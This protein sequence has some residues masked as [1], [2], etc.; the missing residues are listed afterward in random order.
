MPKITPS[1]RTSSWLKEQGYTC[2][3]V[4]RFIH[5]S[6]FAGHG[7]RRDLFGCI[8]VIAIRRG[9]VL[10]VQ[11]M[12]QDWSGHWEKLTA[13]DGRPGTEL[14]LSSGSPFLMI[15][16]RQIKVGW[17][18]RIHYLHSSDLEEPV[19]KPVM[20]TFEDWEEIK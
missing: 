8:D 12:G 3:T 20:R 9:V 17:F 5:P 6:S 2:G 14:W 16:W 1:Q 13:G 7:Y 11:T 19:G 10:A 15:G 18:P 4:E